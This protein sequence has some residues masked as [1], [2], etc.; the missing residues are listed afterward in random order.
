MSTTTAASD[1]L[2][3]PGLLPGRRTPRRQVGEDEVFFPRAEPAC[4]S[5]HHQDRAHQCQGARHEGQPGDMLG[6]PGLLP[7]RRTPRHDTY[8][9]TRQFL[10]MYVAARE[11][12]FGFFFDLVVRS[13]RRDWCTYPGVF[14]NDGL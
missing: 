7:G 8:V 2:G 13:V 11:R 1:M 10:P 4:D 6:R 5:T 12:A 14:E 3:R 9:S